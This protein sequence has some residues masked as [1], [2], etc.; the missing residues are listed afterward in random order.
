MKKKLN[1]NLLK[2]NLKDLSLLSLFLAFHFIFFTSAVKD[3]TIL[4]ATVLVNT[5]PIFS[6]FVS[7]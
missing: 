3:T 7:S 2:K 5:T 1:L 6:M 4:N